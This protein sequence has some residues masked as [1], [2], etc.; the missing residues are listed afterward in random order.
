M[1]NLFIGILNMSIT[2]GY[3]ILAVLLVRAFLVNMPKKY[4]YLLWSVVGFR[5]VCPVSFKSVISIFNINPFVDKNVATDNGTMNYAKADV[6][7]PDVDMA[8]STDVVTTTDGVTA[9]FVTNSFWDRF[10]DFIPYIWIMGIA[11][12]LV[13]GIV[14]FLKIKKQVATATKWSD[15]IYQSENISS[16]C[17][18]GIIKPKIYIPY[19]VDEEYLEY[20]IAHEKY[21]IKRGDNVVKM[22]AFAMLCVHWFNPL[23]WLAFYLVNRDMEMSCDEWVLA[24]NE[25][26]KKTYSNALLSFAA[27]KKFPSPSP[28]CFGEGSVKSRIKNVLS[29]KQPKKIFSVLAIILSVSLLIACSANPKEIVSREGIENTIANNTVQKNEYTAGD[30]IA[31][32]MSISRIV[33]DGGQYS[34]IKIDDDKITVYDSELGQYFASENVKVTP[35]SYYSYKDESNDNNSYRFIEVEDLQFEISEEYKDLF[36]DTSLEVKKFSASNQ[37]FFVYYVDEKPVAISDFM[38]IYRLEAPNINSVISQAINENEVSI[39]ARS[40]YFASS[41]EMLSIE[42]GDLNK[43]KTKTCETAYLYVYAAGLTIEDG[44]LKEESAALHPCAVVINKNDG[45]HYT[46]SE[47]RLPGDGS[48]YAKDI[49][50]SFSKTAKS[51]LDDF[52]KYHNKNV[53]VLEKTAFLKAIEQ[54][55]I[56]IDSCIDVLIKEISLKGKASSDLQ[57]DYKDLAPD[58][59]SQLNMY[60]DYTLKYVYSK[61]IKGNLNRS[62]DLILKSVLI[63]N[64]GG[65]VIKSATDTGQEY[66]DLFLK[67]NQRLLKEND[68]EFMKTSYPKGY[69]LLEMTA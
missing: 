59:F 65:E 67:H 60:G 24:H 12:L 22:I 55:Y 34:S 16:P 40:E 19:N 39:A 18:I 6:L 11:I 43:N 44:V 38:G 31:Q 4:S 36:T 15:N 30:A 1:A 61:F 54:Y 14:S 46:V 20:V 26:I 33:S 25:G 29:F 66:F 51:K 10:I 7:M 64:L 62:E 69:L 13:M 28:L 52:E 68:E 35:I 37:A 21:H 50:K 9:T 63:D 17:I 56:D 27:N 5:L 47:Y 53:Q 8:V 42:D 2:A 45:S 23:C 57:F 3:I 49:N 48:E 41:Y 58:E 32:N